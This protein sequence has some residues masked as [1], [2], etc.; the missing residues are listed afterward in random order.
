MSPKRSKFIDEYLVD[1]NATQAAK[2][3]GY[4]VPDREGHRLLKN[5][6]IAAEVERR[7]A[8]ISERTGLTV[9]VLDA[10]LL[11]IIQADKRLTVKD[12]GSLKKIHELGD[13]EAAALTGFDHDELFE[14]RGEDREHVGFTRKLR[15]ADSVKAIEVGYRRLGAM[16]D[17]SPYQQVGILNIHIHK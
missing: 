12:D 13:A 7:R 11:Q 3:A 2:R 10:K 17:S 1:L 14:G 8:A 15:F 5:A 6:E 4:A 9:A 16:K